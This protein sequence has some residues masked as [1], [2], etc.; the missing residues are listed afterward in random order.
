MSRLSEWYFGARRRVEQQD[1]IRA[2]VKA[3][4]AQIEAVR[5]RRADKYKSTGIDATL[6]ALRD[7]TAAMRDK[8]PWENA[9]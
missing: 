2:G 7:E 3:S 9:E 5:K 6:K 8:P 4:R 1:K